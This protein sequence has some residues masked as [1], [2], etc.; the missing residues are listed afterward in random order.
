MIDRS[1]TV[2]KSASSGWFKF[3]L[4][5]ILVVGLMVVIV[6]LPVPEGF[7]GE[8]IRNNLENDIDASPLFYTEVDNIF[9]MSRDV[10]MM[11][12]KAREARKPSGCG[13]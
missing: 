5:L 11:R 4:G 2:N 1:K 9:E 7:G 13:K 3:C 10:E 6:H 8:V 12:S